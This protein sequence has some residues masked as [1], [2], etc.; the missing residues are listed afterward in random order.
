MHAIVEQSASLEFLRG[1]SRSGPASTL[2][3]VCLCVNP[4]GL[5]PDPISVRLPHTNATRQVKHGRAS[6]LCYHMAAAGNNA[7]I[8]AWFAQPAGF[9]D[10]TVPVQRDVICTRLC[11]VGPRG[12]TVVLAKLLPVLCFWSCSYRWIALSIFLPVRGVKELLPLVVTR[13]DLWP[14]DSSEAATEVTWPLDMVSRGVVSPAVAPEPEDTQDRLA[15]QIVREQRLRAACETP[16]MR[17]QSAPGPLQK[18][19]ALQPKQH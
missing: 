10:S 4:L 11:T 14:P 19:S 1:S 7:D 6:G 13:P 18:N 9:G 2:A 5:L 3:L 17:W 8:S 12:P 16:H 15:L